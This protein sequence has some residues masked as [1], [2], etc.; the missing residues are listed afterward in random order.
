[1]DAYHGVQ[2]PVECL[3]PKKKNE[4]IFIANLTYQI[5]ALTDV[6]MECLSLMKM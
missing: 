5:I 4:N 6:I 3:H 1:M 2:Q